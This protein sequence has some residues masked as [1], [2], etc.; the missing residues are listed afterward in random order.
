LLLGILIPTNSLP[1]VTRLGIISFFLRRIVIGHGI[2][3]FMISDSIGLA[4]SAYSGI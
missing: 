2:N 1:A 4:I 3:L